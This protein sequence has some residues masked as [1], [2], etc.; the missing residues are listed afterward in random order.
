MNIT[1]RQAHKLIDKIH[2][3]LATFGISA[4]QS[5]NI[6]EVEDAA[7]A[8]QQLEAEFNEIVARNKSLLTARQVIRNL[9]QQAN[10]GGVDSTIAMRKATLDEIGGHRHI[11]NTIHLGGIA[12]AEALERKI[13]AERAAAQ[14]S[15]GGGGRFRSNDDT[16]NVC[17][18]G[19]DEFNELDRLIAVKQLEVEKMED[20]L[21]QL[22]AST[23]ITLPADVVTILQKEGLV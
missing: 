16:V 9:I 7:T 23:T 4:T 19:Q 5:V 12:S 20:R 15:G 21:S 2:G 8:F 10:V 14:T 13:A 6:W 22:N 1:L 11:L 17:L 18:L 3:R